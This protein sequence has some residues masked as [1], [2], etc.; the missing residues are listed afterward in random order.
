[1]PANAQT[2]AGSTMGES[3]PLASLLTPSCTS[4]PPSLRSSPLSREQGADML[5]PTVVLPGGPPGSRSR[6]A[7]GPTCYDLI[8]SAAPAPGPSLGSCRQLFLWALS[9]QQ[10]CLPQPTEGASQGRRRN[11]PQD[12]HCGDQETEGHA[13]EPTGWVTGNET[14]VRSPSQDWGP[15]GR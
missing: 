8:V 4:R 7:G 9:A 11:S 15:Q 10:L 14:A 6:Q 13:E 3:E 12:P 2:R 1:M 5:L